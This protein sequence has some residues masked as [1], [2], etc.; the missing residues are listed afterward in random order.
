D[1]FFQAT[2]DSIQ[3]FI[4]ANPFEQYG[5]EAVYIQY[6][7]GIVGGNMTRSSPSASDVKR[8]MNCYGGSLNQYASYSTAQISC[9]MP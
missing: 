6:S 2:G 8:L 5:N 7:S 9:A 4:P 3:G 1:G